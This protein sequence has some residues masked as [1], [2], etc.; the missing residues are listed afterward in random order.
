VE[1]I[2]L[3][4]PQLIETYSTPGGMRGRVYED[5]GQR[6]VFLDKEPAAVTG[7]DA[8]RFDFE[9]QYQ[10]SLAGCFSGLQNSYLSDLG[11]VH[12]RAFIPFSPSPSRGPGPF[13]CIFGR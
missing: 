10:R 6:V 8:D 12:D 9:R 13:A 5:D 3:R 7:P 1:T 4:N 2:L 11:Q